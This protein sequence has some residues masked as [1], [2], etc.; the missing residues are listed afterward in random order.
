MKGMGEWSLTMTIATNSMNEKQQP[1]GG[2]DG[3]PAFNLLIL[4]LGLFLC[5]CAPIGPNFTKPETD[6]P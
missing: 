3:A 2:N 4:V 6:A 1:P 5:S